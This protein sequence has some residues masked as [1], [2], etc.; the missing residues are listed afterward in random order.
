MNKLRYPAL[1]IGLAMLLTLFN[2]C[3]KNE[4]SPPAST[5]AATGSQ[6]AQASASQAANPTGKYDPSIEFTTV[7]VYDPKQYF[8]PGDDIDSNAV[9]DYYDTA[10]GIKLK[11]LWAVTSDYDSK[12]KVAIASDTLPDFFKASP[13]VLQQLVTDDM[14]AS[15]PWD[16]YASDDLKKWVSYDGGIQMQSAT[17]NGKLMAVPETR[18]PYGDLGIVYIRKDWLREMNLSEPQTMDDLNNI[19]KAFAQRSSANGKVFGY[20]LD[21]SLDL[22]SFFNSYHLYPK[23]WVKDEAGNVTYGSL[24]PRMKVAL[25]EL[26]DLFK[27]GAIDPEFGVK[28]KNKELELVNSDRVGI[29]YG[30]YTDANGFK[31][32]VKDDKL[33]QD[34]G[35]YLLPS[36]DDKPALSQVNSSVKNYFAVS[37]KSKHPEAIIKLANLWIDSQLHPEKHPIMNWGKTEKADAENHI[38]YTINPLVIFGQ[39]DHINMG[40]YLPNADKLKDPSLIPSDKKGQIKQYHNV[41]DYENG[42]VNFTNWLAWLQAS[43]HGTMSMIKTA[44]DNNLYKFDAFFGAPTATMGQK[45]ATLQAKEDEMMTKIILGAASVDEYDSFIAEWKKL[46]GDQITAEVNEW[47]ATHQDPLAGR[48]AK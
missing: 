3:S 39:A 18:G 17:F 35:A 6:T 40:T 26:Q 41:Q 20:F 11:N 31:N 23:I 47:A 37:K 45:M 25:Q 42:I 19:A 44:Y 13:V 33:V 7:R 27:A 28:D 4:A 34:W 14:V 38:F 43:E 9:Y 16:E 29:V 2:A 24:D 15:L 46:G 12:L 36:V 1:A 8:D 48:T 5:A 30:R 10:L 32:A 21:K 22:K